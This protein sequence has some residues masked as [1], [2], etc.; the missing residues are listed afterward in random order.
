MKVYVNDQEVD[1]APGMNVRH[2]LT[3]AGLINEIDKGK[4]VYDE[5]GNEIGLGGALTDGLRINVR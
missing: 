4:K 1:L 3:A 5:M 2:A